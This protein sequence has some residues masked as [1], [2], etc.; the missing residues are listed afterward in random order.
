MVACSREGSGQAA[1]HAAAV[2]LDLG[3]LAVH[4]PHGP[5]DLPPE[6]EPDGLVPEADAEQRDLAA[7]PSDDL[8]RDPRV[9]GPSRPWRNDDVARPQFADPARQVV[10]PALDRLM[11]T[12][13]AHMQAIVA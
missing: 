10:D 1:K 3:R 7:E 13:V 8:H 9:L 2:V 11:D 12:L 6:R 4:R 5:H